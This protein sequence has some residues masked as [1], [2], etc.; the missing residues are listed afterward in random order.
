MR[1]I[2]L[3]ILCIVLLCACNGKQENNLPTKKGS[4]G[5]TLEILLVADENV[6]KGE[7]KLLIDSLFG[8]PQDGLNTP[9][10]MFDVVNIPTSSFKNTEMFHVHRNVIMLDINSE[11]QNKVYL[12]HDKW[13]A[14]QIVFDFA[15]KN[16]TDLDTLFKKYY[17]R[18]LQEIYRAE[19]RRIIKAFNGTAGY[20]VMEK[21][22]KQFGFELTVSGEFELARLA[23]PQPEMG[24]IR[25][26]TKDFGIGVLVHTQ[27]YQ[28]KKVFNEKNILN[29][30]DSIM[31]HVGGPAENSY[32]G[33]ERRVDAI[34]SISDMPQSSYCIEARGLWRLF[35]DFMGG[36]Y[37]SYT[38]L[39]PDEKQVITLIAYV[40]SPRFDKRD[41]L[42]QVESICHSIKFNEK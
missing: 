24:W 14:P 19:H 27:P 10:P 35:G 1:K 42:M 29:Q 40:Y 13:S 36:P 34:F 22:K 26:E 30:A 41:Y 33:T 32:M 38:L 39:S 31:C 7:T 17:P 6:Y 8:R 12:H 11:N 5:K 28:D 20:E 18:M 16:H 21:V 2:I 4:S 9:E 15:A 3:S 37:I 25:K 23:N